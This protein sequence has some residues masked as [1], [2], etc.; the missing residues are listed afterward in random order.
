MNHPKCSNCQTE[1]RSG[2]LQDVRNHES[3]CKLYS[4]HIS[5]QVDGTWKC[6]FENCCK[7]YQIQRTIFSHL[8]TIHF[9][10]TPRSTSKGFQNLQQKCNICQE[11]VSSNP[12]MFEQHEKIC[13][14]YHNHISREVDGSW[15]CNFD[16][17]A[18]N[19][20]VQR[21]IFLH[22]SAT[23]FKNT[24]RFDSVKCP[25]CQEFYRK[26][27]KH[28]ELCTKFYN[29][30]EKIGD[31]WRCKHKNCGK[32][33]TSQFGIFKHCL[34]KNQNEA[35]RVGL[36]LNEALDVVQGRVSERSQPLRSIN[37]SKAK[38]D[39]EAE[40]HQEPDSSQ[41][42]PS[43]TAEKTWSREHSDFRASNN[44]G[45]SGT[46]WSEFVNFALF[47]DSF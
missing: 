5:K 25:R 41:P 42:A 31:E 46:F 38:N 18:R 2:N 3:L 10:N 13:E 11:E 20:Q 24:P 7:I 43:E 28:E 15:R 33:S 8:T 39:G 17:C 4:K 30:V 45:T 12:K 6:N 27:T 16:Q 34:I 29:I 40:K 22:M 26:G 47:F 44:A 23:H 35:I 36:S 19:F 9:K 32:T 1:I 21:A 14:M 37:Q